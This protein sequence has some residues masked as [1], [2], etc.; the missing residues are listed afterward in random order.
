MSSE[1]KAKYRGRLPTAGL[2]AARAETQ[3]LDD[4][5]LPSSVDWREKGGVN[6]IKD[7]GSCGSCWAFSSVCAMEGAHFVKTGTLPNLAE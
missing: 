2:M 3:W 1:E 4:T 7:Q 5:Q 6:A